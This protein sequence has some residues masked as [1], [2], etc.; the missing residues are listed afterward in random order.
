MNP[1]PHGPLPSSPTLMKTHSAVTTILSPLYIF[2]FELNIFKVLVPGP[3]MVARGGG[4]WHK[5]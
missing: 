2:I 5:M 3:I 4:R 1:K